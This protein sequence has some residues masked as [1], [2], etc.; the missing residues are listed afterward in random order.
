MSEREYTIGFQSRARGGEWQDHSFPSEPVSQQQATAMLAE[1]A[2]RRSL[3]DQTEY[4]LV[5][6][7]IRI[8][9]GP[10]VNPMRV[11]DVEQRYLSLV[12]VHKSSGDFPT[13]AEDFI[14]F[15][16][17]QKAEVTAAYLR[18][19]L[20]ED[21]LPINST[22]PSFHKVINRCSTALLA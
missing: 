11:S 5:E 22:L 18:R 9:Y 4:R 1:E 20:A 16:I 13:A 14:Q 12:A 15:L 10:V 2:A 6:R 17:G 3:T 7:M 19:A 8:T 21:R